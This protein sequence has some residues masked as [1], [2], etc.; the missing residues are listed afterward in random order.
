MSTHKEPNSFLML[1]RNY[2]S[3]VTPIVRQ[4]I[5]YAM[6]ANIPTL[7]ADVNQLKR[8]QRLATRP[9]K[10]L[11]HLHYKEGLCFTFS[12]TSHKNAGASDL[13]SL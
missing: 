5:H 11:R 3:S 6:E 12:N 8:I 9:A 10:A 1:S 7:G 4:C 13:T 2:Y